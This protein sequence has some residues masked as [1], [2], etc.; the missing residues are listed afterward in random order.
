MTIRDNINF[1]QI[2]PHRLSPS[3]LKLWR[4]IFLSIAFYASFWFGTFFFSSSRE[5]FCFT[6]LLF[7]YNGRR[8]GTL[9]CQNV[10]PDAIHIQFRFHSSPSCVCNLFVGTCHSWIPIET[11]SFA[12]QSEKYTTCPAI[13]CSSSRDLSSVEV[14]RRW[15]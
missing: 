7:E 13:D 1:M 5:C 8:D 6:S 14:N 10:S 11:N 9:C 12:Y 3:L 15:N 4:P 2:F